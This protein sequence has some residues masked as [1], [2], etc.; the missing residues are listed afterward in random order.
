MRGLANPL[1]LF[2]L[3]FHPPLA[4]YRSGRERGA[5]TAIGAIDSPAVIGT[6]E[7]AAGLDVGR[8]RDLAVERNGHLISERNGF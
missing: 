4:G 8:R 6:F 7:L 5:Q 1:F 2:S 3:T